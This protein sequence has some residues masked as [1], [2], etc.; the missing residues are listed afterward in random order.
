MSVTKSP[1]LL[2]LLLLLPFVSCRLRGEANLS[3][4]LIYTNGGKYIDALDLD[5]LTR[6]ILYE[7]QYDGINIQSITKIAAGKFLFSECDGL[8]KPHCLLKEFEVAAGTAKTLRPGRMPVYVAQSGSVFFYDSSSKDAGEEW[9][10]VAERNALDTAR[11][12]AKAP[13]AKLLPNGLSYE[14][15]TPVVE[16]SPDEIVFVGEDRQLWIY[17]IS[18]SRLTPTGVHNARPKVWRSWT[19]Q[20]ICYDWE[21]EEAY[22]IDLKT[23]RT[24]KLPFLKKAWGIVYIPHTDTLMYSESRL[25]LFISETSDIWAYKFGT[26]ERVKVQP[27]VAMATGIWLEH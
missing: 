22:Q 21:S 6:E 26:G 8:R 14:L 5:A 18:T 9:L 27:H 25:Y 7:G 3:G 16:I 24:E 17:Q 10:F 4:R 11:R 15:E 12:I 1:V 13:T 19:Q 23:K 20:L 2:W